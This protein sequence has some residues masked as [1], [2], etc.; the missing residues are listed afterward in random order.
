MLAMIY[1]LGM[2]AFRAFCQFTLPLGLARGVAGKRILGPVV[3]RHHA[4]VD[5]VRLAGGESVLH[6]LIPQ[7][8]HKAGSQ[9]MAGVAIGVLEA[10][11]ARAAFEHLVR[12]GV[13]QRAATDPAF[14]V[15]GGEPSV[16]TG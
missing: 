5:V 7:D 2:S 1:K 11:T 4:Q 12:G 14:F 6:T 9:G 8:G 10:G 3:D 16:E 13:G 15:D